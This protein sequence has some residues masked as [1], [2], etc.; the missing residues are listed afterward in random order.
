MEVVLE[1]E[2]DSWEVV[3]RSPC[4]RSKIFRKYINCHQVRCKKAS[5]L[6]HF[7]TDDDPEIDDDMFVLDDDD[8]SIMF[9]FNTP[10]PWTPQI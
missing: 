2:V 9:L 4:L 8:D 7:T 6:L 5:V 10:H 1:A 3:L